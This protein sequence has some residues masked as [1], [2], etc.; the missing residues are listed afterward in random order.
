MQ[1]VVEIISNE[2]FYCLEELGVDGRIKIE[3]MPMDNSLIIKIAHIDKKYARHI[4][5]DDLFK[6][7]VEQISKF[8]ELIAK[9][10]MDYIHKDDIMPYT[11][12][13]CELRR[14]DIL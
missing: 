5:L 2:L 14:I 1:N 4:L 8:A 13:N 10:S 11:L 6:M 3:Y 7:N 9:E 12:R